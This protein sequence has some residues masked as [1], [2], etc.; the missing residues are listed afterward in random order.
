MAVI[1]LIRHARPEGAGVLL[2]RTD[3]PLAEGVCILPLE[4]PV[5]LICSSPLRRAR[6]TAERLF[7]GRSIAVMPELAER[8]FGEWDG[9]TWA[10]VERQWP[11]QSSLALRDWYGY[12]PPGAEPW[13]KFAARVR[14]AWRRLGVGDFASCAVVAHSGVNAILRELAGQ[15]P[16]I[17][18]RQEYGE[19]ITIEIARH[20]SRVR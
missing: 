19:T 4:A 17:S 18:H 6:Q 8:D 20:N 10:E 9:L 7:P 11:G 3:P 1:H 16:A 14:R 2:G 13:N 5:G 15:G 12:T